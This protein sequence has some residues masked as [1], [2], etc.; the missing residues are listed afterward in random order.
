MNGI[1]RKIVY[2]KQIL[3][4]KITDNDTKKND[5]MTNEYNKILLESRYSLC[6]SGSGPN[7][8]RL[9]ESLAVGSIPILLADTLELPEHKLWDKA[10]LRIEEKKYKEIPNI[11]SKISI[12]K[13]NEMRKNCLEIYNDFKN[14]FI[15]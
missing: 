4:N 2:E 12:E 1:L 3:G 6:P 10:I 11:L 13:E 9:W 5:S 7:S 15:K 14:N 8:I